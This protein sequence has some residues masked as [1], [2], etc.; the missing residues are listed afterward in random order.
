MSEDNKNKLELEKTENNKVSGDGE[1]VISMG[2]LA[3]ENFFR[4]KIAVF[5]GFL[6]LIIILMTVFAPLITPADGDRTNLRM[7]EKPPSAENILGTDDVG[8]DMLTRILYGG[9]NSLMVAVLASLISTFIGTIIGCVAGYYGGKVDNFLM[10]FTEIVMTFPYLPTMLVISFA[11]MDRIPAERKIYL[12]AFIIG[13]LGWG[14]LAR[15]I[16]GQILSLREKEFME[17]ATAL[18]LSDFSKI[19]KHLLPNVLALIVTS[20]M[21][22]FASAI[23]SEV[24][25]S[26]L[27]LGVPIPKPSWGNILQYAKLS[28]YLRNCWWM[29]MPCSIF[30]IFSVVSINLLG[31][32]LRDAF[33]PKSNR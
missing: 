19:F 32:G 15:M 30:V 26:Y 7:R 13:V 33:D 6:F 17:A 25:L 24:S 18:G 29:W 1:K 31:E 10:R 4:N 21:L 20:M 9:R 8:R 23:L 11:L 14:S 16:R 3:R 12:L 2:Q 22:S 28:K 5:G 27:G